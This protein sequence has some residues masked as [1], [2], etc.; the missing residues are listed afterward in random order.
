MKA[1]TKLYRKLD[2]E[3]APVVGSVG[4][5]GGKPPAMASL[6]KLTRTKAMKRPPMSTVQDTM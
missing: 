3:N 1:G 6:M 4:S 5:F 2:E